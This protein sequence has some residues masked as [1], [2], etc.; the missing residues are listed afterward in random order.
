[1]QIRFFEPGDTEMVV[2]LLHDMSRHYNGEN[3]SPREVVHAN[4]VNNI[5]G[6]DSDVRIVVALTGDRAVG[7]A[8]ISILYPAPKERGQLFMKELYV[9]SDF[10]SR[11]V[12]RRLM[13]WI[14]GYAV[15]RNCI[16]FDWTV[17]ADNTRA[18]EF[19]RSIGAAH[20]TD[21]LYFRLSGSDLQAFA[22]RR[23]AG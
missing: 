5:L 1:M 14:A 4:L 8:M 6:N 17:D 22:A 7:V 19:Y 15:T 23:D 18:V 12:G 20:V 13:E 11:E 21:K 10:R 16:R 2:D 3:A 9:A